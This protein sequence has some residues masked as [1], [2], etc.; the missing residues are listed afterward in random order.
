MLATHRPRPAG[1]APEGSRDALC[2]HAT[3][4][5]SQRVCVHRCTARSPLAQR[6]GHP[7]PAGLS[8]ARWPILSLCARLALRQSIAARAGGAPS[9]SGAGSY[10]CVRHIGPGGSGHYVK[11][12]H[13]GIEYG[14][15]Q[16]I[17]EASLF[18]RG[19]AGMS[20]TEAARVFSDLNEGPLEGFLMET[21]AVVHRKRDTD[22]AAPE[23]AALVIALRVVAVALAAPICPPPAMP[24]RSASVR[25]AALPLCRSL[26]PS[27]SI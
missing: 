7:L 11:M 8:C 6:H 25:S 26:P 12:V 23:G 24:A 22:P 16:L 9:G 20:A 2:A 13:N 17:A 21:T 4:C 14:D 15:M 5:A 18:C 1:I 3:L 19:L 27:F 10:P